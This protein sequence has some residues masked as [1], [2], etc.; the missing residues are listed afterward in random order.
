MGLEVLPDPAHLC[1]FPHVC[2]HAAGL[3]GRCSA[4]AAAEKPGTASAVALA[5][6]PDRAGGVG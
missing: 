3:T 4:Q 1:G 6:L 2:R 5:L